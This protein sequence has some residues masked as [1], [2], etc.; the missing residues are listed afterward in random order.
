MRIPPRPAEGI[1]EE[2]PRGHARE[3]HEGA[4]ETRVHDHGAGER[5]VSGGSSL[6]FTPI[7]LR[8]DRVEKGLPPSDQP[9]VHLGSF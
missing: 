9:Q 5:S 3:V 8:G 4:G 6:K 7:H 2:L 1:E